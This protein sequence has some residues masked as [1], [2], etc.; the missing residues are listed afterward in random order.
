MEQTLQ[1][2]L[3]P[4]IQKTSARIHASSGV[5]EV[6]KKAINSNLFLIEEQTVIQE[7]VTDCPD[8]L[9]NEDISRIRV[10]KDNMLLASHGWPFGKNTTY[11]D[12]FNFYIALL[13]QNGL[14]SKWSES[15]YG[16]SKKNKFDFEKGIVKIDKSLQAIKLYGPFLGWGFGMVLCMLFFMGEIVCARCDVVT[17]KFPKRFTYKK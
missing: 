4:A 12:T 6:L 14:Q 9:T 5:C 1:Q 17:W 3:D 2:S 13:H 8:A 10:T 11:L 7:G 16:T 15:L